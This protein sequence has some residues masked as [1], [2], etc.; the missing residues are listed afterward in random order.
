MQAV[1]VHETVYIIAKILG[2]VVLVE[3]VTVPLYPKKASKHRFMSRSIHVVKEK[4]MLF[5]QLYFSFDEKR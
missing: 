5:F 4:T 2:S 1:N 3:A